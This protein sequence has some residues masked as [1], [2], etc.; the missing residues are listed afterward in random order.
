MRFRSRPYSRKIR[1]Q[2]GEVKCGVVRHA[3]APNWLLTMRRATFPIGNATGSTD[4]VAPQ[5]PEREH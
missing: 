2:L 5:V 3:R 1:D 4:R